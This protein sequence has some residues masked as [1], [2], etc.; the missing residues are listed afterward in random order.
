MASDLREFYDCLNREE[1]EL[2]TEIAT[3]GLGLLMR[4]AI[5]ELD[6][7]FEAMKRGGTVGDADDERA[8]LM[9]MGVV[10]II[11]LAMQAHPQ[12]EAPTLTFQ[13]DLA[14]SL[15]VLSLINKVGTIEHGRRVAQSLA[16]EAGK[17]ERRPD[18]F[19]IVLPANL[20]DLEL[21]ER[22]LD[23]YHVRRQREIFARG[24]GA[25]V[26][27]QVGDEV[28]SLLTAL[29]YPFHTHFIGYEADPTLDLY[30]FGH[31]YNEIQISKGFDTFHF[32]TT[33]GNMTFQHYQLAA[34]FIV[35]VGMKHRAYAQALME[36]VPTIRIEDVLTVSVTTHSFLE[37]LR[38][39]INQVG[40][41]FEGHVPVTEEGVGI[42]FAV[43]S[44]SRRNLAL[45]DRP[46]APIPP[47]I[48]CSDHH[49]IRP[50]A[51][52]TADNV[53]LFLLNSLQHNFPTDY[54]RAQRAREGVMQRAVERA[55][56]SV[57]PELEYRGNIKLR[58]GRKVLTDI[59]LVLAEQR[60]GRVILI[61]LK[62]Q[63]PYGDD[64]ATKQARTGRL[65]QQVGD[66]L[67]KVRSWLA[68]ADTSELRATLRLP[69][70]VNRPTV[71]LLVLTRHYAHSLRPVVG[72]DDAAF[73]NWTQL[74]TAVARLRERKGSVLAMDDLIKELR[75]LSLP[76]EEDYLPEPPSDWT[77]GSLRFTIEQERD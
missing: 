76:E 61:Q 33:F 5:N 60:T 11:K 48:R 23:R 4:V 51:G 13:R 38:E 24:Y 27:V 40:E 26:D 75:G 10:R 63:D 15:P 25:L 57:L 70:S 31:A 35:S 64:L 50:L 32:A 34:M 62:H 58:R 54:D 20:I 59:D 47:L 66:W 7:D 21:H 41:K 43:L 30:F 49:V 17:I 67:S 77:V 68:A 22:E 3:D 28:R 36:K 39:F 14:Y 37:G 74:V 18:C 69:S 55:L 46:G 52:A 29:V 73:S 19:R 65:N 44:V 56:R 53:M 72:G 42:I 6:L 8:Y 16:A 71:S 12:F 2:A 1:A 9:R 45:L